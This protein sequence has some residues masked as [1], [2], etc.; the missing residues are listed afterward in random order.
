MAASSSR[1]TPRP[2][3]R[4]AE[5]QEGTS[6]LPEPTG[7]D[8]ALAWIDALFDLLLVREGI[9]PQERCVLT[10][11]GMHVEISAARLRELYQRKLAARAGRA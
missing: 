11:L 8:E 6:A 5:R 3:C 7:R 10:A 1:D 9:R 2:R 4:A